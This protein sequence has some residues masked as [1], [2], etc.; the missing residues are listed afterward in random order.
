[1]SALPLPAN[2]TC[3]IYRNG[4]APP[5]SPDV[6]GVPINFQHTVHHQ[7]WKPNVTQ[8]NAPIQVYEYIAM[9]P[10]NTDIRD[11]GNGGPSQ[12]TIYIPN[13]NGTPFAVVW[14]ERIGHPNGDFLRAFLTRNTTTFP[15]TNL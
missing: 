3:D 10:P 12:D 15:T 6:A 9:V 2:T 13:Q 11:S 4:R 14:V 7:K 1:M 5:S 8:Q